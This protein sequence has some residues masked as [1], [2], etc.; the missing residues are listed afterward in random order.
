MTKTA[1]L[2]GIDAPGSFTGHRLWAQDWND[3]TVRFRLLTV[4]ISVVAVGLVGTLAPTSPW[5]ALGRT[6]IIYFVAA[7]I[8]ASLFVLPPFIVQRLIA[9]RINP[10]QTSADW[11]RSYLRDPAVLNMFFAAG[12]FALTV[13]S[14]T[15][16]KTLV[17]RA[18][19]F[20]LDATFAALDRFLLGGTDAWV[21]THGLLPQV[22]FTR[23]IDYIY[24]PIFM[25]MMIGYFA[26]IGM[27][28]RPALRYT[29][30]SAFLLGYLLV[31]MIAADL[32][33]S[34]GPVFDGLLYGDGSTFGALQTLL[35]GQSDAGAE[36]YAI[37]AQDYL[38]F[39]YHEGIVKV[40]SGI[41]AMPS[42]HIVLAA[43]WAFVA[44]HMSRIL[45]VA[46]TA[47]VLLIW[48]GSVHLG[49][50]YFSDGLVSLIMI[51]AIWWVAGRCMGL[52]GTS[53][54]R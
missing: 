43:L 35:R 8:F 16:Y 20:H 42:M 39:A 2:S 1:P 49:W 40:G 6:I 31:G 29:Y 4:V 24:H 27:R 38:L 9:M 34:A 22:E 23:W 17:I 32:L 3:P 30:M 21:L 19:G 48:V 18:G 26:C 51:M 28:A 37:R 53:R 7:A 14:F 41:S 54:A 36:L 33:D 25:P 12:A 46:L 11:Y 44:W 52:Y 47:Y 10:G 50:H 15:V 45:G 13:G 5:P